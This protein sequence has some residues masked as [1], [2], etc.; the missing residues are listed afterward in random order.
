M[1]AKEKGKEKQKKRKEGVDKKNDFLNPAREKGKSSPQLGPFLFVPAFN[2]ALPLGS[3]SGR[4]ERTITLYIVSEAKVLLLFKRKTPKTFSKGL[5]E[6]NAPD[7]R[8]E[9]RQIFLR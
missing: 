5:S 3:H 4:E 2:S 1:E 7:R 6:T 9:F 8:S